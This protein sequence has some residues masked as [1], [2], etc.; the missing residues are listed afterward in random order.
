MRGLNKVMLIG[1]LA[2]GPEMRKTPSGKSVVS[3]PV[4]TNRVWKT[5]SGEKKQGTEFHRIVAW[6]NLANICEKFL[7]KGSPVYVEGRIQNRMYTGKNEVRRSVTE[8]IAD[9]VMVLRFL[10]KEGVNSLQISVPDAEG[11]VSAEG[12]DATP[13]TEPVEVA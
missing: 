10:K 1:N 12:T 13:K 3:F 9:N 4:A 6:E 7:A 11:T 5:P 8:V 2:D